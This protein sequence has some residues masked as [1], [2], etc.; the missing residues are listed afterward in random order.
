MRISTRMV[1]LMIFAGVGLLGLALIGCG[2]RNTLPV[3]PTAIPTLAPATLPPSA[4]GAVAPASTSPAAGGQGAQVFN[5]NCAPCHNLTTEKKVGPG[6]AGIFNKSQLPNGKPLTDAN[7]EEWIHTGGSGLSGYPPMPGLP[8]VQG[9]DMMTALIDYLKQATQEVPATAAVAS[10]TAAAS[11]AAPAGGTASP[12]AVGP[13][14]GKGVFDANCSPCHSLTAQ[15]V[16]GPGLAELF[17]LTKLPNGKP[18]NETNLEEWVHTGGTGLSGYPPMP[19]FPQIQGSDLTALV[20]YLKAATAAPTAAPAATGVA[21]TTVTAGAAAV[22]TA[23]TTATAAPSGPAAEGKTVFESNCV[24][25]HTLTH[26]TKVGPGLAGLFSLPQLVNNKPPTDANVADWI[27]TGGGAMPPFPQIQGNQ[28]SALLAYLKEATGAAAGPGPATT[29]AAPTA[30]PTNIVTATAVAPVKAT[31]APAAP[32][33]AATSSMTATVAAPANATPA[34]AATAAPTTAATSAV[35]ATVAAPTN[36]TPAAAATVAPTTAAS[37]ATPAAATAAPTAKP[38][39]AATTASASSPPAAATSA[40]TATVSPASTSATTATVAS[41]APSGTAAVAQG[42]TV[43][44]T[45]CAGCHS[46]TTARLVGPGLAGM[47]NLSQLPN[48]KPVTD[49]NVGEWIHTGGSGL[50]GYPPMPSL[51]Q[52]QGADLTA[53]IAYLKQATH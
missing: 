46:L 53:L 50:T 44:D 47:F 34:P 19:G 14:Q 21:T 38:T 17:S 39:S 15:K 43:F 16:V 37:A 8:Q 26:E 23:T 36:P 52:I 18:F 27:H 25:C 10:A 51:P 1:P 35:T 2:A 3:A 48:G 31:V 11:P 32:T 33:T 12:A 28:M 29:P 30:A 41:T 42:K 22:V 45:H 40:V 20:A 7:M 49:A 4:P 5:A 24:V 6:L 13:A 9:Q